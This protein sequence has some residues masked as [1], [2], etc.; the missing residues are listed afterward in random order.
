MRESEPMASRFSP[1]VSRA[2]YRMLYRAHNTRTDSSSTMR[3]IACGARRVVLHALFRPGAGFVRNAGC[4]SVRGLVRRCGWLVAFAGLAGCTFAD[5]EPWGTVEGRMQSRGLEQTGAVPEEIE[6]D[7]AELAAEVVLE[8][9]TSQAQGSGGSFD[10]SNPPP[11][12]T[13][14]HNGHCH[15]EE[16]ELVAY[17][18]VRAEM[19]A[20]GGTSTETLGTWTTSL[21]VTEGGTVELPGISIDEETS[22]DRLSL[23]ATNLVIEGTYRDGQTEIPLEARLGSFELGRLEGLD[24]GVGPES[25]PRQTIELCVGWSTSWF[26]EVD[27]GDLERKDGTIRLTRILNAEAT[28]R[29]VDTVKLADLEASSCQ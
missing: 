6:I 3:C 15:S 11:G 14:C 10:P 16:G 8:S 21:E 1:D 29:V 22:V 12:Y 5:G 2:P 20:S 27:P 13:L 18:E 7:R 19:N 23:E 28:T 17:E 26:A 24:V 25:P 9:V 4:R